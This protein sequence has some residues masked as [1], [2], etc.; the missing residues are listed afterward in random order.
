MFQ[1]TYEIENNDVFRFLDK[2]TLF[3]KEGFSTS[4]YHKNFPVFL[5][6]QACSCHPPTFY[7]CVNWALNIC[8]DPISF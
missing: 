6:I 8:S 2:L 4:A 7:T 1:F 3:T 5:P